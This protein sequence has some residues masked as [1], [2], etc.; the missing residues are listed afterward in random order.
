M[1]T[2]VHLLRINVKSLAA[3]AKYIRQEIKKTNNQEA[4]ERLAEHK[5]YRLKPEARKAQLCLAFVKGMPYKMVEPKT[6]TDIE[7]RELI[8]KLKKFGVYGR[9]DEITT[10]LNT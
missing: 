4:K 2:I 8:K 10:W 7:A 9:D 1:K 5:A 3:E 6:K